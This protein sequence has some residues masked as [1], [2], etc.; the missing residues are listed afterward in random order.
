MA[1]QKVSAD[2]DSRVGNTPVSTIVWDAACGVDVTGYDKALNVVLATFAETSL[3]HGNDQF[4]QSALYFRLD[5]GTWT[6]VTGSSTVQ[7]STNGALT[8]GNSVGDS[9][10]CQTST[11]SEEW[12]TTG[13]TFNISAPNGIGE[14]QFGLDISAVGDDVLIE[15][16]LNNGAVVLDVSITTA[17][18]AATFE[19]FQPTVLRV[20]VTQQE[21]LPTD[22]KVRGTESTFLATAVKVILTSQIS[23]PTA[24]KVMTYTLSGITKDLA[25]SALGLCQ[26]YLVKD[27]GNNT[28]TWIDHVQSTSGTGAYEF[29]GLN[30]NDATYQVIAW[31]D[32]APNVFDVT[33]H[34]L[35]PTQ[36]V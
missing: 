16:S 21:F 17:A 11:S 1:L 28:Y 29:T 30:D 19:I 27:N 14:A 4:N 2:T 36:E 34:V 22:L 7:M 24:L 15:F 23:L 3:A 9:A 33:D 26:V 25:G 35:Q 12:T 6:L 5:G 13:G 20:N 31:R 10:G 32:L 8:E 18:G